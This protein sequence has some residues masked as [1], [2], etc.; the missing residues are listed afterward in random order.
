MAR[1]KNVELLPDGAGDFEEGD[2]GIDL[3]NLTVDF[4]SK[5]ADSEARVYQTLPTG[6]YHVKVTEVAVKQCG[7]SSKNPGKPFYALQLTVQDGQYANRKI[8]TN[9][10]LFEGALYTLSQLMKAMDRTPGRG[11]SVPQ[12]RE[13]EGYDFIVIGQKRVDRYQIDEGN[14]DGEGPKP[15]KFEVTGFKKWDG[16]PLEKVPGQAV[17]GGSLLP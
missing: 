9:V 12:P 2:G 10:M 3:V 6:A 14:W 16:E 8:F 1:D 15:T 4:S 11:S 5:E 7:P 17:G 13:L